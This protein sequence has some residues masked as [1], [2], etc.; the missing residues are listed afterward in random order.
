MSPETI[1]VSRTAL[2]PKWLEEWTVTGADHGIKTD[3][4]LSWKTIPSTVRKLW[5]PSNC[6]GPRPWRHRAVNGGLL[7]SEQPQPRWHSYHTQPLIVNPKSG[8]G[9]P[10]RFTLFYYIGQ[11]PSMVSDTQSDLSEDLLSESKYTNISWY[12]DFLLVL[13]IYFYISNKSL[14]Y[15]PQVPRTNKQ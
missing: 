13:L 7:G 4:C 8:G 5:G 9:F 10:R 15:L 2:M 12:S 14:I 11:V 6:R 3:I 1:P